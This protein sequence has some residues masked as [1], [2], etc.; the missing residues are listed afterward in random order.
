[1][2]IEFKWENIENDTRRAKV[3]GGWIVNSWYFTEEAISDTT[4]FVPDKYHK[5][6]IKNE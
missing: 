5:W 3:I 1:M 4:V 2:E 6:K